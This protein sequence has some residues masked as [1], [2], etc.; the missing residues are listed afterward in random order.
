MRLSL[1]PL[2]VATAWIVPGTQYGIAKPPFEEPEPG[3]FSQWVL[4]PPELQFGCLGNINDA[5]EYFQVRLK[6]GN[7]QEKY[8]AARALWKGRTRRYAS[9]VLKY[10]AGP[11][12][13]GD[14]FR[15]FQKEVEKS[16][17][18]EGILREL[19]DGDYL[20]GTWLAF[21]RPHKDLVPSLIKGLKD[22]PDRQWETILALGNSGDPRALEPIL[23]LLKTKD[24]RHEGEAAQA[25]GYLADPTTESALIDLIGGDNNWAQ[26]H[27][28]AALATF[29]TDK[30]LPSLLKL[31]GSKGYTG[32]INVRGCARR[33]VVSIER[34]CLKVVP[35][36]ESETKKPAAIL[37]GHAEYIWAVAYS[38]DGKLLASAS[39][40]KTVRLWDTSTGKGTAAFSGHARQMTNVAFASDGRQVAT[41]GWGD[42]GSIRFLDVQTGKEMLKITADP[43]GLSSMVISPNGKLIAC[44]GTISNKSEVVA[45]GTRPAGRS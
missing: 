18:A 34:R 25:L 41:A 24:Y 6:K 35:E 44:D 37:R 17:Q 19:K 7:E 8:T 13:G 28:C 31:A 4:Y 5:E 15:A 3:A 11:P 2:I 16:M 40:D 9:E 26:Q 45:S 30:A 14:G 42:D 39:D 21:L 43:G 33:A 32:A 10:V 36:V 20:W 22:K 29:G 12:P 23:Q 38:P 27:A 1:V